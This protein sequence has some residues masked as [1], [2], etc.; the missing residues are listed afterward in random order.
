[1]Y[2]NRQHF[3]EASFIIDASA[4]IATLV[5][6]RERSVISVQTKLVQ[7]AII[8]TLENLQYHKAGRQHLEVP[9]V[10]DCLATHAAS[11]LT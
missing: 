7:E 3:R 4:H 8:G 10:I 5:Q 1:V 9:P 11:A 2:P 6:V